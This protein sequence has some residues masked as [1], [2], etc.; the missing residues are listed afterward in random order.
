MLK[1]ML[2]YANLKFNFIFTR[3]ENF[4]ALWNIAQAR[5]CPVYQGNLKR[6]ATAC[7]KSFG[8]S[9]NNFWTFCLSQYREASCSVVQ[10]AIECCIA[11]N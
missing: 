4:F 3:Q 6:N 1:Y 9:R 8:K 7:D 10:H 11:S 5:R 2:K